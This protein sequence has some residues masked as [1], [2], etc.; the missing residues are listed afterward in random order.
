[1]VR[2]ARP[3]RRKLSYRESS[4]LGVAWKTL[5]V[6]LAVNGYLFR[7][8]EEWGSERRGWLRR[9]S[10][11]PKIQW[12]SNRHC[13]YG[14]GK[15]LPLPYQDV[16]VFGGGEGFDNERLC[17]MEIWLRLKRSFHLCRARTWDR[18]ISRPALNQLGL[19]APVIA[20]YESLKIYVAA[21]KHWNN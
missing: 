20:Y 18:L 11:V 21:Q 16:C 9:S 13:P 8:R 19:L 5:S 4:R 10:A 12:G 1:M 6:N 2:A 3:W 17:A 15:L 14:Y 7:I